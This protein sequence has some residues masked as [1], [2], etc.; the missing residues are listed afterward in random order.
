MAGHHSLT[1][2]RL[3]N[4]TTGTRSEWEYPFAAAGVNITYM[5]SDLSDL[6]KPLEPVTRRSY[7]L[8]RVLDWLAEG[9]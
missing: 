1:F 8:I 7:E 3:M 4:K 5:L 9:W 6:Y 2:K